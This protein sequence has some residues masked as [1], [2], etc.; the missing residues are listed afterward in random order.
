VADI[1]CEFGNTREARAFWDRN[2]EFK[3]HLDTLI[4]LTN[5]CFGREYH[6]ANRTEDVVFDLGQACRDDFVEVA[7]LAAHGHGNGAMK[8]LRGM[9]ERDCCLLDEESREGRP[10]RPICR[11]PRTPN[12]ASGSESRLGKR[13][14]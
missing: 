3:Q 6:P 9:F 1:I 11:D 10:V 7:F 5:K 4:K 2:A 13:A 12:D 14:R 8:L